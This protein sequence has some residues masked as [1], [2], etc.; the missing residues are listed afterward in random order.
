MVEYKPVKLRKAV[1]PYVI[2]FDVG[3]SGT[4]GSVFDSLARPVTPYRIKLEHQF[5]SRPDGTN[6]IDPDLV[7]GEI[8]SIMDSLA[9]PELAGQIVGVGIDT[10]AASLVGVDEHGQ[11]VT[12]CFTYADT[13]C[14]QDVS[15]L[16]SEI[17]ED[18]HH[19]RTGTRLHTSYLVPRFRWLERTHPGLVANTPRWVSLG[20][21]VYLRLLGGC[22]AGTS[23][24]AWTG[25]LDRRTGDWDPISL[26]LAGVRRD[27]L[28]DVHTPSQ[29]FTPPNP[30]TGR[31]PALEGTRWFPPITDGIA[32]NLGAGGTNEKTLV[33]SFSTSGA[34]RVFV[35][36]VPASIPRGL[37]CCRIGE[38]HSLL[39]G[40]INDVGRAV[41]WLRRNVPLPDEETLRAVLDAPPDE[42]T[43]TVLPYFTGERSPGYAGGARALFAGISVAAT[44]EHLYRGTLEGI[45]LSFER[46]AEQLMQVA[47]KVE[48]VIVAGRVSIDIPAM[49]QI[50][51]DVLDTTTLPM[52]AKRTTLRGTAMSVLQVVDEGGARADTPVGAP[53][54][55][56]KDHVDYY[57][58]RKHEFSRLYEVAIPRV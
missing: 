24:A 36:G 38:R 39:G 5:T 40:A 11:A 46:V 12:P 10:F 32:S 53:V 27:Q 13:R 48:R 20:E 43:P 41:D 15:Q 49:P 19:D 52:T 47:T 58:R 57:Q 33:A 45:A 2:A 29:V 30:P 14:T 42:L 54:P 31:W 1:P 4:R 50:L 56:I 44:G 51:A 37:W 16:R 6:T 34:M 17:N 18:E 25:M 21:Y 3:S 55:A 26:E 35:E 23:T 28:S 22:V 7:V 8:A 9:A